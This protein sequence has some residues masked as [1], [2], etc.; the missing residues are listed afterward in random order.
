MAINPVGSK[1]A[2][3]S[4]SSTAQ[5]TKAAKDYFGP[6][7]WSADALPANLK[8]LDSAD[9]NP[10]RMKQVG[11]LPKQVQE[12]FNF[13]FQNVETA[14]WGSVSAYKANLKGEAVYAVRTG[15]D[16]DD[17]YIEVFNFAGKRIATG[18]E[19]YADDG[20]G[21]FTPTT[22]WDTRLGAVRTQVTDND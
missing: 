17:G 1:P 18:L 3:H 22:T 14:D 16:G 9:T 4:A 19:G 6:I 13:Y 20:Q 10:E 21:G 15:T 12:A 8:Q 7:D 11:K 5:L 2:A